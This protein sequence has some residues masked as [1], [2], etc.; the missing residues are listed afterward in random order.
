MKPS[1]AHRRELRLGG[2]LYHRVLATWNR[3]ALPEAL[4]PCMLGLGTTDSALTPRP[5]CLQN[6]AAEDLLKCTLHQSCWG[7]WL[8]PPTPSTAPSFRLMSPSLCHVLF[9][10]HV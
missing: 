10:P 3:I 4:P 7:L 1:A 6:Q 8:H 5:E 9:L 2:T